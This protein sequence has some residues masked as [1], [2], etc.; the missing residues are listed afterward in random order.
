MPAY[1]VK[2][3]TDEGYFLEQA[4]I[5]IALKHDPQSTAVF[6][7]PPKKE[8]LCDGCNT[9]IYPGTGYI[10]YLG[11]KELRANTPY[12][13]IFCRRCVAKFFKGYQEVMRI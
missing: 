6:S 9:N 8:V 1:V 4:K 2:T 10:V 5:M 11:R 12:K 7:P 3:A 13:G